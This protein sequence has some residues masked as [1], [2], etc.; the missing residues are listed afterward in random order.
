MKDLSVSVFQICSDDSFQNNSK[1][2]LDLLKVHDLKSVD[3]C[4]F[5]ENALYINIDKKSK[6]PKISLEDSFFKELSS[7]A[8]A[9]DVVVHLGSVPLYK[10][11]GKLYNTSVVVMADG[12]VSKAYDKIHLFAANLGPLQIDEGIN[13][14][15][16]E[17]PKV[18]DVKG[19]KVGLS[20]CFDLRFSELYSHYAKEGC[21][22]VLVP[23]AFFRKTG[24]AHWELLLKARAVENQCYVVAPGQVGVHKSVDSEAIRK[25][26]GQSLAVHPWG[27]VL[28]D[29]GTEGEAVQT[30][31]LNYDEIEKIKNSILMKRRL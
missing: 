1:K 15:A 17:A 19:W 31:L 6:T 14:S 13:Y 23:S 24:I 9:N 25:S 20:I 28:A 16:G 4:V 22:L 7:L 5:P 10:E 26:Y 21:D 11:D 18:L 12:S 8:K 2:I 29:L 3:L 30:V 27:N